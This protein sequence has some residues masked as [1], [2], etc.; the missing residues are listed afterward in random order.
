MTAHASAIEATGASRAMAATAGH[1]IEANTRLLRAVS[2]APIALHT[3]QQWE[4]APLA[5]SMG[6]QRVFSSMGFQ[7][8]KIVG[9]KKALL[10]L[11]RAPR[12]VLAS[13]KTLKERQHALRAWQENTADLP[14][15]LRLQAAAVVLQ[16]QKKGRTLVM[17]RVVSH[18]AFHATETHIL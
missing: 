13:I 11:P 6:F 16:A 2:L 5:S 3:P 18:G 15:R 4:Q 17:M 12:V 1:V 10:E 7:G 9:A 8:I 14:G